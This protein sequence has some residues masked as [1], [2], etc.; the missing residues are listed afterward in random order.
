MERMDRT[1]AELES[2]DAEE[3][4]LVRDQV[5]AAWRTRFQDLLEDLNDAERQ[6]AALQLRDLVAMV[7]QASGGACARGEGVAIGGDVHVQAEGGS[8][9]AVQMRMHNVQFGNPPRPG[10]EESKG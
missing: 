8:A 4:G 9:A 10:P 6:Q 3:V 1:A 2:A 7:D 5:A